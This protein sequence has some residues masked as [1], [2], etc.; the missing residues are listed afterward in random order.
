[1]SGNERVNCMKCQYYYV[2]WDPQAPKGCKAFGF[3]T[4]TMPSLAVFN[5]SGKPCMNFELKQ[6][7]QQ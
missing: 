3:K 2:T 1:M 6:K 4:N 7:P 5:S